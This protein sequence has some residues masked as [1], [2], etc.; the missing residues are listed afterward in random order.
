MHLRFDIEDIDYLRRKEGIDDVELHED[1]RGLRI[2]DHVRL[3]FLVK[4]KSLTRETLLVRITRIQGECLRGRLAD[5]PVSRGLSKLQLGSR[6]EF[7]ADHIHSIAPAAPK[8]RTG[9]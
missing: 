9:K 8:A 3:T 2:G 1:I 4:D 5:Q 6:I 7:A